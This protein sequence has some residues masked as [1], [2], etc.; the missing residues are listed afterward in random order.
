[1]PLLLV[2]RKPLGL[3]GVA[4]IADFIVW[5]DG[6]PT[7]FRPTSPGPP[8]GEVER[9]VSH[10]PQV[11]AKLSA[12]AG[13]IYAKAKTNLVLRSDPKYP[14]RNAS[15]RWDTPASSG[16]RLDHTIHLVVSGANTPDAFRA[17]KSI[18]YGHT[19]KSGKG[20]FQQKRRY[21]GKWILH[22]AAGIAR[23][24]KGLTR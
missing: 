24:E 22:D 6:H 5:V 3:L 15:I 16:A 9:I 2:A 18:E 17:A 20:P 21:P 19:G 8:D 7:D 13:K 4:V 14:E 1:M 10:Q 23:K 11:K 12:E